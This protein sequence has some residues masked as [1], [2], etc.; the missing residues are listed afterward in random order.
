MGQC[1][2]Y[3]ST[4]ELGPDPRFRLSQE[5]RQLTV[6]VDSEHNTGDFVYTCPWLPS[7]LAIKSTEGGPLVVSTALTTQEIQCTRT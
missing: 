1:E 2:E 3:I 4:G 6:G 7:T 5:F